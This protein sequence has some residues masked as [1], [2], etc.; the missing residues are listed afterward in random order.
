ME[1]VNCPSPSQVVQPV[2]SQ[3]FPAFAETDLLAA[4]EMG[5]AGPW[6]QTHK[7]N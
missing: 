7:E 2:E 1:R 4:W 5:W 3:R 6:V